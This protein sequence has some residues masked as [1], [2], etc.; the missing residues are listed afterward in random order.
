MPGASSRINRASS[1]IWSA[2]G[3]GTVCRTPH[4]TSVGG[5]WVCTS[6]FGAFGAATKRDYAKGSVRAPRGGT[7]R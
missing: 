6:L 5:E 1:I 4:M 2:G 7:D 3:Q